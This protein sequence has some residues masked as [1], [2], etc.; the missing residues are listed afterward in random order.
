MKRS[1]ILRERGR[2]R[3]RRLPDSAVNCCRRGPRRRL[4]RVRRR[5][6]ARALRTTVRL[7]ASARAERAR[8]VRR[9]RQPAG[10]PGGA[11]PARVAGV[12]RV[13]SAADQI[14]LW[15]NDDHPDPPV[16]VRRGDVESGRAARRPVRARRTRTPRRSSPADLLRSGA[17]HAVGH[18][19]RRRRSGSD[20]RLLRAHRSGAHQRADQGERSRRRHDQRSAASRQA[21]GGRQPVVREL[22]DQEDGTMI[23]GD[24]L[25]PSGGNAGGGIY[26][27]VPAMPYPGRRS[28]HGARAVA[29]R[30]GHDLR[31]ARRRGGFVEL[32]PGRGNRQGRVGGREP[33]RGERRRRATATSSCATRRLLQRFTGYYRP[34]D[35]DIDPIAAEDGVFRACWANTGRM[36]HTGSSLVENSGVKAEIMCLVENPPS[37]AVPAP[38]TGHDPDGRA[39]RHRQRGA[40]DV[41]TT[42]RSSR[43]PAISSSSKTARRASSRAST[44]RVRSCAATTS[45]SACRTATTTTR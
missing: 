38:L 43:T 39:F 21:Q 36:S 40:G 25:A 4:R 28:D 23:Y 24:E 30:I 9:P 35:M 26:K 31:P 41:S 42:S 11:G 19:H 5:S 3:P 37:T 7:H 32:G 13:A 20:R 34:E 1:L 45:G 44:R 8:P 2:R 22:R 10:H 14:A 12:E 16:R 18:D 17:P 27:F 6:A 33:G 15:P 29:A